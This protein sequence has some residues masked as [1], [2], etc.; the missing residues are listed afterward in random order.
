M[1]FRDHEKRWSH[2]G[3][4]YAARKLHYVGSAQE[5]LRGKPVC[6]DLTHRWVVSGDGEE[7]RP[8]TGRATLK[9]GQKAVFVT[10]VEAKD[11]EDTYG[12]GERHAR[13]RQCFSAASSAVRR[14]VW[15]TVRFDEELRISEDID[16]AKRVREAGHEVGYAPD[17]VVLHYDGIQWS[18]L[19]KAF[20]A[21]DRIK[22]T[23]VNWRSTGAKEATSAPVNG[24]R[25]PCWQLVDLLGPLFN[26]TAL[27]WKG[28][29]VRRLSRTKARIIIFK[30][31]RPKLS[32]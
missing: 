29:P 16:F 10:R 23:D 12:N 11:T 20:G 22:L 26:A 27:R 19:L 13:W 8:F 14:S 2:G 5:G 32:K 28:I 9:P 4:Q 1:G 18:G 6:I 7:H 24:G 25:D 21:A 30:D 31:Q 3:F 17:S 15:E